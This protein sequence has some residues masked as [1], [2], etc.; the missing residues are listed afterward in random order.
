VSI[1]SNRPIRIALGLSLSLLAVLSTSCG[2]KESAQ[3]EA[4]ETRTP[5]SAEATAA[6]VLTDANVLAMVLMAS[7]MDV[8]NAK[9]ALGNT[10][11]PTVKA[12]ANQMVEDH[13][14]AMKRVNDLAEKLDLK[15]VDDEA[16]RQLEVTADATRKTIDD[17]KGPGFDKAYVD[18]EVVSHQAV[19]D[20][21]DK[22]LIPG[23]T[24]PE[25]KSLLDNTRSVIA[26]HLTHAKS[27]RAAL[28]S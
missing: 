4:S 23:A 26:S 10:K 22:S 28:G 12:F 25:V 13:T 19:L 24:N 3:S 27:V 18:N 5:A 1:T 17:S 20:L 15:P 9:M 21:L 7:K 6:P 11:N 16:S 8:E 2:K 14:S